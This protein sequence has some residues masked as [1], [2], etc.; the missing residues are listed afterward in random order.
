MQWLYENVFFISGYEQQGSGHYPDF[1][2]QDSFLLTTQEY[3]GSM[4]ISAT[5]LTYYRVLNWKRRSVVVYGWVS[6]ES[7][8]GG[9][10]VK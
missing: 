9:S 4:M 10:A 5:V 8:S 1:I 3:K 7:K 6:A 2:R